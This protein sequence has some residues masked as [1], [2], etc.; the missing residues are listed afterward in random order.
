M[1]ERP[2]GH[3]CKA[4]ISAT[5][6]HCPPDQACP[7][8]FDYAQENLVEGL[9]G[10]ARPTDCFTYGIPATQNVFRDMCSFLNPTSRNQK[11]LSFRPKG[12]ILAFLPW[13]RKSRFLSAFGMTS[14]FILLKEHILQHIVFA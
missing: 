8:P 3:G 4:A 6:T 11:R 9:S 14:F 7:E 13:P 1:W 5:T 12:E 10:T 2:G